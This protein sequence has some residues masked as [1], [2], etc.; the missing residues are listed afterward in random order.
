M[1]GMIFLKKKARNL[2]TYFLALVFT[3]SS[4]PATTLPVTNASAAE[5]VNGKA[6]GTTTPRTSAK[7]VVSL[8]EVYKDYFLI[9]NTVSPADL[10]NK[11]KYDFMK[12]HYNALTPENV[13]KPDSIWPDP[14]RDPSFTSADNMLTQVKGDGFYTIG[15]TLAWHNQSAGWP[16]SGQ[17]YTEARASLKRYIS[18]IAGH[19]SQRPYK[20]DA[21]DVVNEAMR[22]NPDNPTDWRNALRS[23]NNPTERP[24]KWFE[25]YANGGNGWDYIYDAFLFAR[26][27][28][29]DATL[30]YNDFNDEELPNKAI[31]IS[32]MIKELNER[33]ANE[34]PKANGRKLI[35]GIGIQGHYN[36]RL[37][38]DNLEKVLKIYSE[39]GCEISITELDVQ[40][41]GTSADLPPTEAQLK[42]QAELY[43]KL[44]ML[45]KKYSDNIERVTFWG[46]ADN[47]SWRGTGYPLL[48]DSNR[49]PKEA[50]WAIINPEAYL[51][52]NDLPPKLTSFNFGSDV[53]NVA[54]KAE[55]D[56]NVPKDVSNID[57]SAANVTHQYPDDDVDVSV[58]LN[59]ASG[60]VSAGK[61]AVA[62]VK[63]AWKESPNISTTYKINFGHMTAEW[64]KDQ[65]YKDTGYR[66]SLNIRF[67]DGKAQFKLFQEF[68]NKTD[69]KL[70][71][72]NSKEFKPLPKHTSGTLTINTD[73]SIDDG[74]LKI[75]K[76]KKSAWNQNWTPINPARVTDFTAQE[77]FWRLAKKIESGKTYIVVSASSGLALTNRN[78]ASVP[79]TGGV[80]NAKRGLAGTPVTIADKIIVAPQL[81]QDNMRFI[82]NE[83]TSPDPGPYTSA[84]GYTGYTMLSLVHGGLVAPSIMWRD[85]SSDKTAPLRTDTTIGDSALDRAVWF[86][87]SIDPDTGETTLFSHTGSSNYTY[88]L[89]GSENG[90]VGQGGTGPLKEYAAASRVKLFEYVSDYKYEDIT[91]LGAEIRLDPMKRIVSKRDTSIPL[92]ADVPNGSKAV[93]KKDGV[94]VASAT[95][96]NGKTMISIKGSD[97]D[98]GANYA[99]V[100]YDGSDILGVRILPVITVASAT[101]TAKVER[102]NGNQNRLII[103]VKE[104]YSDDSTED[105]TEEVLIRN[106]SADVYQVGL[107]KVYVDTKGNN[108][109]RKCYIVNE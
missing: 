75:L 86:N 54:G 101:P 62:T 58:K 38:V 7:E 28:A 79:E 85:L 49:A 10:T 71:M 91:S 107:Y 90:F 83:S 36:L 16:P 61:R 12:Y 80:T 39:T 3:L 1:K 6:P 11:D 105:F 29:P 30:Y 97:V 94:S 13:T 45:Y 100:V 2:L 84:N 96:T 25:A 102:L 67:S 24:S 48:F 81:I 22:D 109:I 8:K 108:K 52:L 23:G 43:A 14:T 4:F 15:H 82:F 66:S 88:A 89:H 44:F 103:T 59:P 95:F 72:L 65:N 92:T 99:V 55:F 31:A 104:V 56:V 9:G 63:I 18:T 37:K 69:G 21:W 27:A 33:Y 74:H 46:V 77:N 42:E 19:Y 106:N 64:E 70:E 93:L 50:Y 17:K 53:F 76:L 5:V 87:T 57:F 41:N 68:Y 73:S 47:N 20:L 26:E 78:V 60:T 98:T 32:S 35:E 40:F 51:G 34:H